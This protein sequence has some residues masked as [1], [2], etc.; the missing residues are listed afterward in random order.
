MNVDFDLG[1]KLS[2]RLI[3]MDNLTNLF[4]VIKEIHAE[5]G[6]YPECITLG[7]QKFKYDK[8]DS[9]AVQKGELSENNYLQKHS[10]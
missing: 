9:L 2:Y 4:T 3:G 8:T 1:V 5:T 7:D 6:L 10:L